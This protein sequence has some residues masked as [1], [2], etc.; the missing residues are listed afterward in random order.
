M[1][2]MLR[3]VKLWIGATRSFELIAF[4]PV[5][6][7][8]LVGS[9]PA[10]R[11]TEARHGGVRGPVQTGMVFVAR[12]MVVMRGVV[13]I[14]RQSPDFIV[15]FELYSLIDGK[16]WNANARQAEVIGAV[17]MSGFGVRVG[18]NFEA[19]ILRNRLHRGI[20][21]CALGP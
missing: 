3:L 8:R 11:E 20:K 5:D 16:R 21:S 17:V 10:E 14:L 4:F 15:A 18:T 7:M 12:L 6:E 9:L 19:E 13:G 2:L 1:L